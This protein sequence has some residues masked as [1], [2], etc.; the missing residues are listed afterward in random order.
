MRIYDAL[1][2]RAGVRRPPAPVIP[3]A[4]PTRANGAVFSRT[5][6]VSLY[7]GAE[8]LLADGA[9]HIL[10]LMS[11]TPGEGTSTIAREFAGAVAETIGRRVLL[12]TMTRANLHDEDNL[13]GT[14]LGPDPFETALI[15]APGVPYLSGE[16]G[17]MEEASAHLYATQ[18]MHELFEYLLSQF[19]L[20]VIDAPPVATQHAGLALVRH[21]G[22]VILVVEAERTRAPIVDH[23]RRTI[24]A[25]GGH[26]LGIVLNKRRLYIPRLLY[27][28]L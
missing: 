27:Q 19:D 21:V 8:G 9:P 12:V 22:G 10:Q 17:I 15:Q 25:N 16:I 26:V 6:L 3:A 4:P 5:E 24:E 28:W 2:A 18:R 14:L 23:A 7:Q 13:A 11:A 20:I 1:Q